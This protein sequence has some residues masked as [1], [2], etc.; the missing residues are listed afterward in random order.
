MLYR[1]LTDQEL[2]SALEHSPAFQREGSAEREVLLRLARCSGHPAQESD[3]GRMRV[4]SHGLSFRRYNN[5]RG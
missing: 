4:D 1:T 5:T 2:V 3:V